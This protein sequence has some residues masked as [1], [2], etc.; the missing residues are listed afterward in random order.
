[1]AFPSLEELEGNVPEESRRLLDLKVNDYHLAEIAKNMSD[2]QGVIT[3]L[4]LTEM[5]EAAIKENNHTAEQRRLV[6][7]V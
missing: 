1:M 3:Y 4:D 5:E 6:Y 2:W 7:T